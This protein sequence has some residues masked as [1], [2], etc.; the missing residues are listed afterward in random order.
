MYK[1]NWKATNHAFVACVLPIYSVPRSDFF[2]NLKT[3]SDLEYAK[4]KVIS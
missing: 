2:K 3:T 1:G 4:D